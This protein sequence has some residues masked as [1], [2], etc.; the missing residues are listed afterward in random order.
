MADNA[1]R[2]AVGQEADIGGFPLTFGV[3]E[4]RAGRGLLFNSNQ[5]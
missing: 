1:P 2:H 4:G 3:I 5:Q